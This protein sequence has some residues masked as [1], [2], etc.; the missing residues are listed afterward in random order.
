MALKTPAQRR[1]IRRQKHAHE[2]VRM[3]RFR[4]LPAP[5]FSP[6]TQRELDERRTDW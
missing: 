1:Q 5:T 4:S 6:P 2:L 3:G